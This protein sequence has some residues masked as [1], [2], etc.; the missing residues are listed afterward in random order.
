M[1][2]ITFSTR[3]FIDLDNI[4]VPIYVYCAFSVLLLTT[5]AFFCERKMK[6]KFPTKNVNNRGVMPEQVVADYILAIITAFDNYVR[7]WLS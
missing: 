7:H 4:S 3:P 1:D 5:F 6:K 2:K